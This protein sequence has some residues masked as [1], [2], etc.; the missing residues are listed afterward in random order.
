MIVSFLAGTGDARAR[1]TAAGSQPARY[2]AASA[3]AAIIAGWALA[4]WPEILPGL[5]VQRAA[6]GHASLVA[7]TVALAGGALLLVPSLAALF[8]L[9]LAGRFRAGP[10]DSPASER[11][12]PD[13]GGPPKISVR[14]AGAATGAAL[15]AGFVLL[16]VADAGWA[17]ALGVV[18][19]LAGAVTGA[20]L[21]IST[22]LASISPGEEPP[23]G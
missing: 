13:A 17:H 6:A 14:R 8:R 22:T 11:P 5:T 3:V 19:Y 7:V 21:V 9:T 20:Y 2:R 1:R 16:N 12:V 23:R 10:A 18:C 4:R 15:L